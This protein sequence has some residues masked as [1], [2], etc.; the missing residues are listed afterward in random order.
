MLSVGPA[1]MLFGLSHGLVFS[2]AKKQLGTI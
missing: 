1:L 2:D